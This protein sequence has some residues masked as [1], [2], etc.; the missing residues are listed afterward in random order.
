MVLLY[1]SS[2][3]DRVINVF[4]VT[5]LRVRSYGTYGCHE[6]LALKMNRMD[7]GYILCINV[8]MDQQSHFSYLFCLST[9]NF[10]EMHIYI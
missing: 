4:V 2:R 10:I 8:H 9:P 6:N 1:F 5:M 3:K 7:N